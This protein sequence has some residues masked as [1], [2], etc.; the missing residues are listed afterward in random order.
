MLASNVSHSFADY[1]RLMILLQLNDP[2]MA[3][4]QND[5]VSACTRN[6]QTLYDNK[7]SLNRELLKVEEPLCDTGSSSPSLEQTASSLS[8]NDIISPEATE[9]HMAPLETLK[10]NIDRSSHELSD[11]IQTYRTSGKEI[12]DENLHVSVSANV[13]LTDYIP[14]IH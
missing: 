8:L 9:A 10:S 5:I 14:L 4:L 3:H 6:A 1:R 2:D 11:T 13:D 12:V 7:E